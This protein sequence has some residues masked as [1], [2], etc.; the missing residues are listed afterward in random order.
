[1]ETNDSF[2]LSIAIP[3]Y[4]RAKYLKENLEAI[5]SQLES[6][7]DIV[8]ILVNDNASS[9]NTEQ[10]ILN[11]IEKYCFSIK[12][13][14]MTENIGYRANVIDVSL[15]AKGKYLF[16]LGDDDILSPD[17]FKIVIPYLENKNNLAVIHFNRLSGDAICSKN[18]LHD[19]EFDGLAKIMDYKEFWFRVMSSPNFMSSVIVR[20]DCFEKGVS[21][22]KDDY[23]GYHW[24]SQICFGSIG[25]KCL[26]YYMP[27]VLMRNPSRTW[28]HD[29][30]LYFLVGMNSIFRDLDQYIP[31]IH[32]AWYYRG[33]KTHFYDFYGI[34]SQVAIDA[35]YYRQ[36]ESEL[37][38]AMPNRRTKVVLYCIL[39]LRPARIVGGL[40]HKLLICYRLL[41]NHY[42]FTRKSV[43]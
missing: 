14:R 35:S 28:S 1:M 33:L 4:N 8:E 7:K 24:F 30:A 22:I 29:A 37:M 38:E 42:T 3:T 18:K 5:L 6:C 12:Y 15:R 26:Y 27:L 34:L 11:L 13:H 31:G 20:R 2:L 10:S 39:H 25:E 36:Y 21:F 41:F 40:Y 32:D 43:N 23:Y 17:F 16:L 19:W 9:D